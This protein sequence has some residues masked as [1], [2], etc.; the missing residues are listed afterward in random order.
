M[1]SRKKQLLAMIKRGQKI[2]GDQAIEAS[3]LG[4]G[5]LQR[6]ENSEFYLSTTRV[7]GIR[8]ACGRR[9]KGK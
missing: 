3:Q 7:L 9:S 2:T 6:S 5:D 4:L 8:T 1:M